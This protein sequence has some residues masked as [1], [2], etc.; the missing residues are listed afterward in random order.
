[1]KSAAAILLAAP[2]LLTACGNLSS[3]DVKTSG[4]HA[5]IVASTDGTGS[6]EVRATLRV[7]GATSNQF[8]DLSG[9]DEL[10]AST[11]SG[12]AQPMSRQELLGAISYV[13]TFPVD[14]PDTGFKVDFE[15]TVDVSA[16]D[17]HATLPAAFA[18][19]APADQANA[20]RAA[21]LQVTYSSSGSGDAMSWLATGDC[22]QPAWGSIAGD[23]GVF[24]LSAG[25]LVA[26]DGHQTDTC[27]VTIT[28]AR[29]RAGTLDPAFG[30][31]TV[32]GQQVRR[33]DVRSAP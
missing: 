8:L 31:G 14:A 18:I 16:P 6:T 23:P 9:D 30:S 10:M 13:S 24:V 17:S 7:G 11:T 21:D 25:K 19:T 5:D 26:Y 2:L 27:T 4:I 1:M 22:I 3:E 20:S 33:V 29:T 32:Q 28:V 12:S 15:R